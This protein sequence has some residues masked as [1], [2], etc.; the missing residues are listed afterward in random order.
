[1][2]D[3]LRGAEGLDAGNRELHAKRGDKTA[4]KQTKLCLRLYAMHK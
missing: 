2:V 4:E 1:M 3:C